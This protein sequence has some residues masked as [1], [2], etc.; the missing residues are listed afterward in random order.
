MTNFQPTPFPYQA[1][2]ILAA[3]NNGRTLIADEPGLG[4]TTQALAAARLTRGA[5]RIIIVCPPVLITNWEKETLRSNNAETINGEI[6][7][8]TP[9]TKQRGNRRLVDLPEIGYVIV[10]DSLLANRPRLQRQLAQWGPDMLIVDEAHRLKTP[11]AKRTRAV[12]GL[13]KDVKH[14]LA[15][16]GTPI[17]STPLDLLPILQLLGKLHHFAD[18]PRAF[19][20]RYTVE[21]FWGH[22]V[23]NTYRLDELHNLLER[24]VWSRRTK[25]GVLTDLPPKLRATHWV[26]PDPATLA[27]ANRDLNDKITAFTTS[28]PDPTLEERNAFVGDAMP[29]VAQLRRATGLAKVPA[30]TDWITT[31]LDGTDGEPLI[32]WTI[33]KDVAEQLRARLE[34]ERPQAVVRV[35][36]GSTPQVERAATVDAFQDGGVDVLIAQ[37]VAA[38]VGLTLTRSTTALFVETDWT[39]ANVVQAEDRIHRISQTRPVTITTLIATGTLD[40]RIHDTLTRNIRVLDALTPGSDHHVTEGAPGA[41]TASAL[42]HD[43]IN[44][45]LQEQHS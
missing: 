27:A 9:N 31:H 45:H 33:H 37:I 21:N 4:K 17:V 20:D 39:P 26:T 41:V 13:A 19:I 30:A 18:N 7:T 44:K 25:L 36:N 12:L 24:H 1:D 5:R 38:G 32:V 29:F 11:T 42:I 23:A 8:I 15:L 35:I 34:A 3:V 22:R 10:S 28:H 43:L 2:G 6:A 14:R 40:G 16:T